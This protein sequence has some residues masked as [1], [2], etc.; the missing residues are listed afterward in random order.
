MVV[1]P[2]PADYT[3][4]LDVDV[5]SNPYFEQYPAIFVD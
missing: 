5:V 4:P 2:F 1:S 3:I